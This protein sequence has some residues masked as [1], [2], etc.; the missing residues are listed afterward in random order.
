MFL[1]ELN[2]LFRENWSKFL[3][4]GYLVFLQTLPGCRVSR[5]ALFYINSSLF[6]HKLRDNY[7]PCPILSTRFYRKK[8]TKQ[9][10]TEV[11]F[12]RFVLFG[13][14]RYFWTIRQVEFS[15]RQLHLIS[16]SD[17]LQV[18]RFSGF[19]LLGEWKIL[20]TIRQVE[21]RFVRFDAW[22]IL[23]SI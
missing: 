14:Q 17:P 11:L 7:H 4:A 13:E 16:E 2:E 18:C 3:T 15:I 23:C 9:N 6:I 20:F 21:F 22:K 8:K 1:E 10:K 5:H 19:V 12:D